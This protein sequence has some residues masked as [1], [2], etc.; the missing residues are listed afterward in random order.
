MD[1]SA[2]SDLTCPG[3]CAVLRRGELNEAAPPEG[4]ELAASSAPEPLSV[5]ATRLSAL[6]QG[7]SSVRI[8]RDPGVGSRGG[9]SPGGTNSFV[10]RS[11]STGEGHDLAAGLLTPT[12]EP[13]P[14]RNPDTEATQSQRVVR[15]VGV[16]GVR[17]LLTRVRARTYVPAPEADWRYTKTDPANPAN[18]DTAIHRPATRTSRL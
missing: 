14:D 10:H 18:P 7:P 17:F 11:S 2:L 16:G 5:A 3:S 6:A 12:Q 1:A 8:T 9:A 13:N 15:L 4:Q